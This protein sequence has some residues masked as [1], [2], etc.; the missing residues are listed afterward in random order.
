MSAEDR[1]MSATPIINV[2]DINIENNFGRVDIG[3]THMFG[4]HQYVRA[5]K[6]GHV[7][8]SQNRIVL[9]LIMTTNSTRTGVH[10]LFSIYIKS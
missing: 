2:W 7:Y 4:A 5:S 8:M 6:L 9:V 10:L 3:W 1:N